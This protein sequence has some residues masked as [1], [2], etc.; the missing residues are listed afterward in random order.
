MHLSLRSYPLLLGAVI[1]FFGCTGVPEKG[2]ED[3]INLE[4]VPPT[5]QARTDWAQQLADSGL[6]GTFVLW[7][8]DSARLQASDTAR[9]RKGFLPASTFKVF[10]SLVALQAGAVA[11]EH[12][13]I[14]WD[15]VQ[16]RSPDWNE[17]QDM[18]QAIARSTVWWY[19]VVARRA[20]AERM[21]HW[22]D[23]VG[24]GNHMM[25]D[26]IHLF[27]L[28]GGLRITPLEQIGFMEALHREELPFDQAHQRTVKRILPGDS[29][30]VWKLQGKTGW[31]IRVDEE[32]GWYVGWVQ[33]EGRTAYFAT[34]IDMK[35]MDDVRKR[36]TITYALLE[37]EGWVD[38]KS[39][40]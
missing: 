6:V 34:N 9:A 21:Q 8:P 19:Q 24:Y 20:G 11:N 15:G 3:V 32:Y 31:A 10:N 33:R 4:I 38:P 36:Y 16:R 39:A 27:W 37:R 1:I 26:S 22:L 12:T 29:T 40:Q 14:R 18:A 28:Q 35:T 30:S 5:L 25:G 23:T 13:I 7:E 17:D 2:A